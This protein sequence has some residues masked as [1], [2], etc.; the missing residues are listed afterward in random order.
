MF[1]EQHLMCIVSKDK[2]AFER[3]KVTLTDES[4][5]RGGNYVEARAELTH[6]ET[7]ENLRYLLDPLV[8]YNAGEE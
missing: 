5:A 2:P 3:L 6:I 4:A 1:R 7:K 8:C